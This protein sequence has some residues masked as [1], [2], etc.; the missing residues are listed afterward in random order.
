MS[1]NG[2][3]TLYFDSDYQSF[4][5]EPRV[6]Q[7]NSILIADPN[8]IAALRAINER[9]LAH[10]YV[11]LAFL[12]SSLPRDPWLAMVMVDETEVMF[13]FGSSSGGTWKPQHTF[14]EAVV[15]LMCWTVHSRIY[16]MGIVAD[17]WA[18]WPVGTG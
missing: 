2:G 14:I 12:R 16:I 3:L 11:N 15:S 7:K 4:S 1:E 9:M 13:W 6:T 5:V 18:L 8:I 17:R 10:H